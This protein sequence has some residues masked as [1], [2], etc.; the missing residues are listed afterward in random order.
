MLETAPD[1]TRPRPPP[2]PLISRSVGLDLVLIEAGENPW[3]LR[4]CQQA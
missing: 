2:H 3:P 1:P 4:L